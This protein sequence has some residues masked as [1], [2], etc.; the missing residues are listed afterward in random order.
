MKLA[1]KFRI[2]FKDLVLK[3][4]ATMF[5]GNSYTC[6]ICGFNAS[7]F[8]LSPNGERSN[9]TCPRCQSLER[10][11]AQW[12]FGISKIYR[13]DRTLKILH[14]APDFCIARKFVYRF[15]N[16]FT[17]EYSKNSY[18]DYQLDLQKTNLASDFFD[19]IICNH[20]LEHLENDT[21]GLNE[22]YRILKPK[23]TA[24]IQ[25]PLD[26]NL[27]TTKEDL[28]ITS[29]A[30]REKHFGQ[31]DHYR[32]YGLDFKKRLRNSGF[33]V[34]EIKFWDLLSQGELNRFAMNEKEPVYICIKQ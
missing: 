28:S 18:S 34:E 19:I 9:V 2:I 10:H 26:I 23:G 11:R 3:I 32:L 16:Y 7:K 24:F 29:P 15:K 17:A 25:V 6:P 4:R 20:I 1:N 5:A 13:T 21:L 27:S 33:I 12:L 8:G 14:F 30:E 22:L 31:S